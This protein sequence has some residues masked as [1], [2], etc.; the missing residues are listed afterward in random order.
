MP[1]EFLLSFCARLISKILL[2]SLLWDIFCRRTQK[3]LPNGTENSLA[4]LLPRV[5][6]VPGPL[7]PAL[8]AEARPPPGAPAATPPNAGELPPPSRQP[9]GTPGTGC[10]P[11]TAPRLREPAAI[12]AGPGGHG[13]WARA[14]VRPGASGQLVGRVLPAGG[15]AHPGG[16]VRS[17]AQHPAEGFPPP[18]GQNCTEQCTDHG[19]SSV[20]NTSAETQGPRTQRWSTLGNGSNSL[21]DARKSIN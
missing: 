6:H 7:P 5:S 14:R 17:H 12:L 4:R 10:P 16:A 11:L 19:Y 18:Q 2:L 8:R 9:P 21:P 3:T 20:G 1:V 13:T 15:R